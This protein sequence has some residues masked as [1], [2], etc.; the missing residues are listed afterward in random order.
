VS[1]DKQEVDVGGVYKVVGLAPSRP[2]PLFSA[3]PFLSTNKGRGGTSS[4]RSS[5]RNS[6]HD[7]SVRQQK[8]LTVTGSVL[9]IHSPSVQLFFSLT[10]RQRYQFRIELTPGR[11]NLVGSSMYMSIKKS[12]EEGKK[13]GENFF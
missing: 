3:W 2:F 7:L 1:C 12:L 9:K 6:T 4:S 13:E 11:E 8:K 5:R 10:I